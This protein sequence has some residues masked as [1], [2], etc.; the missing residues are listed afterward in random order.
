M[1]VYA[2]DRPEFFRQAFSSALSQ[3][4]LPARFVLVE[5][6]PLTKELEQAVQEL[7]EA[8]L[9]KQIVPEILSLEQN[10]GLGP[11]LNRGLGAC[12]TELVARMDADDIS[13]PDRCAKQLLFLENHP[14]VDVLSGTVIEFEGPAPDPEQIPSSLVRKK[15]PETYAEILDSA[16]VRNPVNHPCVMYRKSAV[17]A[18]GGYRSMPLFEDYDLWLRMLSGSRQTGTASFA[19]LPDELLL[20]RIDGM[21]ERRGGLR[22][23]GCI[24]RFRNSVYRAGLITLPR[25]LATTAARV[26]VSLLPASWRRLIYRRLLRN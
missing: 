3:S 7:R 20:M 2:K 11:A 1:A 16:P 10:E 14:E 24:L 23:A 21:Y 12:S 26:A 17:L 5:D 13:L 9:Q 19:N 6:G 22:Y 18:A 25:H 8:C 4:F 15:V